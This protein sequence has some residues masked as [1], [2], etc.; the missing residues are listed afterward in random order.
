M[1]TIVREVDKLIGIK[2]AINVFRN[3]VTYILGVH[4]TFS[5]QLVLV[6]LP[7]IIGVAEEVFDHASVNVAVSVL[8]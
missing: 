1:R 7:G 8:W 2:V 5:N 4:I 3:S 6:S